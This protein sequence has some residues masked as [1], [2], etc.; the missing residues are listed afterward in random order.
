[1]T[2]IDIVWVFIGFLL[3]TSIVIVIC[4]L[5]I[6]VVCWTIKEGFDIEVEFEDW[7]E[8]KATEEIVNGL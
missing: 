3:C 7:E 6:V 4:L 1:M 8:D 2:L 5:I